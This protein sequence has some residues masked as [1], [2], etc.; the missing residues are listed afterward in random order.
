MSDT[1]SD[2]EILNLPLK[3]LAD[4]VVEAMFANEDVAGLA[5]Q[6]LVNA[7]LEIDGDP[8]IGKIIRLTP[9]K[10]VSNILSRGYRLDIEGLSEK[11]LTDTEIQLTPMNMVNRGFLQAGQLA[12][13]NAKRGD[14]MPELLKKMPRILMIN[15]NWFNDR[16]N[17]PD[18]T[19][20]VD[21]VYRKP[22]PETKA[23]LLASDKMHIYNVEIPKFMETVLPGLKSKPYDSQTPRLYYWLWAL[24]E[25][26]STGISLMEVIQMNAALQEFVKDDKGFGQYTE[27]YEEVSS[28]MAVRYQFAAWS[29][30]M[31]KL[32][33]VRAIGEAEGIAKGEAIGIAKGEAEGEIKG[34]KKKAIDAARKLL[35]L[36]VDPEIIAKG[37]DLTLEEVLELGVIHRPLLP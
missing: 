4:P 25:S 23:Y 20:P 31:D 24:G 29:A 36:G 3:P 7:V 12:G 34:E 5:A 15:L 14:T 21:L 19:Q 1:M 8:P 2:K 18:F 27:R 11:E 35:S 30:E 16:P 9:Q 22:E 28:D 6:S 26:Q 32:D 17:H 33:I 37:V 13:I 10:T